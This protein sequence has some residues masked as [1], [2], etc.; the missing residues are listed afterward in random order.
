MDS[1]SRLIYPVFSLPIST[2]MIKAINKMNFKFIW[3]NK[4]QYIRKDDMIKKYED[5]GV[6]AIDFDIMNGVLTLKW[7][8]SFICNN[9]SL[10]EIPTTMYC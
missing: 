8:K 7:L 1:L 2:Q 3:R 5:G 9:H 6:N 10:R 4:C